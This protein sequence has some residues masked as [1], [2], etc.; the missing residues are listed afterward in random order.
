MPSFPIF[1]IE[2]YKNISKIPGKTITA[3]LFVPAASA[4]ANAAKNIGLFFLSLSEKRKNKMELSVKPARIISVSAEDASAITD[5][6]EEMIK[7]LHSFF[8][9]QNP[10]TSRIPHSAI[11]DIT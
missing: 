11:T 2:K 1:F 10:K 9:V 8:L 6:N 7:T 5:A 3:G 4:Y